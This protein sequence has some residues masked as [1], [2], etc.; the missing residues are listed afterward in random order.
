MPL[1][2]WIS[3]ESKASGYPTNTGKANPDDFVHLREGDSIALSYTA[4]GMG[5]IG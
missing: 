1:L 4:D 5:K 3:P 2:H